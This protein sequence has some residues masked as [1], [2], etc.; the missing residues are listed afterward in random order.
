[1]PTEETVREDVTM[2]EEMLPEEQP[3]LEEA[4]GA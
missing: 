2:P 3:S 4:Y 1:M